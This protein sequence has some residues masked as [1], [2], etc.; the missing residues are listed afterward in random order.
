MRTVVSGTAI[1]GVCGSDNCAD[2][3]VKQQTKQ[4]IAVT[5]K[6]FH[7]ILLEGLLIVLHFIVLRS[8]IRLG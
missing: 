3:C 8:K 1:V 2:A 5:E 6:T 4:N 7:Q